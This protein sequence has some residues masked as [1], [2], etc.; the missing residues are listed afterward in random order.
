MMKKEK[1]SNSKEREGDERIELRKTRGGEEGEEM[2]KK[3]ER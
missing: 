2:E 1:G 3:E